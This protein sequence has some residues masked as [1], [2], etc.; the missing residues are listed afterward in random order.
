MLKKARLISVLIFLANFHKQ[1]DIRG[2]QTNCG[3]LVTAVSISV[4][5]LPSFLISMLPAAVTLKLTS[6]IIMCY[7]TICMCTYLY[8]YIDTHTHTHAHTH[9]HTYARGTVMYMSQL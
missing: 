7:L 6:N 8:I 3:C 1:S 9:I 2:T 4:S 5:L